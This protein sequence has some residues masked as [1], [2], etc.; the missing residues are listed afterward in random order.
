MSEKPMLIPKEY[1][2][3]FYEIMDK[4]WKYDDD[5]WHK[6]WDELMPFMEFLIK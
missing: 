5:T 1:S 3:R 6:F 4:V 2:D